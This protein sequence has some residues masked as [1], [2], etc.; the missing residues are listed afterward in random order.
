MKNPEKLIDAVITDM[1]QKLVETKLQVLASDMTRKELAGG[2]A[3]SDQS[4]NAA[5]Q[6][7]EQ[8][9]TTLKEL[10]SRRNLLIVKAQDAEARLAI[11][12]ALMETDSEPAQVAL[13]MIAERTISSEAEA[14]AISD[15]RQVSTDMRGNIG[16]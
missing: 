6:G 16:E 5:Q 15:I 14:D 4:Y 7:I 2:S 8:L 3:E 13:D 12:R 10:E 1:R 11:A 9:G